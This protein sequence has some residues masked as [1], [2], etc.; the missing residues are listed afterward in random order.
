MPIDG[1]LQKFVCETLTN[2]WQEPSEYLP[3]TEFRSATSFGHCFG[4]EAI[5]NREPRAAEAG[6]AEAI[7]RRS[8]FSALSR[9]EAES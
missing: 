9:A 2:L 5:P 8:F 4:P 6:P 7:R 1:M 3:N